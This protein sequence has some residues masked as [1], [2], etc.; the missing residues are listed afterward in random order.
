MFIEIVPN[1]TKEVI[2]VPKRVRKTPA[3]ISILSKEHPIKT[4][5]YS[6]EKIKKST[7]STRNFLFV[8]IKFS[9]SD[10]AD[11]F[12]YFLFNAISFKK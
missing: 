10:M 4:L 6:I 7:P 8:S 2:P 1:A 9:F 5:N 11:Y 3:V 12:I